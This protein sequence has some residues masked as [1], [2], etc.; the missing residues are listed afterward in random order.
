MYT[1]ELSDTPYQQFHD[2]IRTRIAPFERLAVYKVFVVCIQQAWA[3]ALK[4]G[5]NCGIGLIKDKSMYFTK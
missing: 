2:Q 3:R 5:C 1:K 4:N